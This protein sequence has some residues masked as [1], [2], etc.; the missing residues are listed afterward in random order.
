MVA[1]RGELAVRLDG[2]IG[3]SRLFSDERNAGESIMP[4]HFHA[5]V[6]QSGLWPVRQ[7]MSHRLPRRIVLK[8]CRETDE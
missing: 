3:I 2:R 1:L 6:F 8:R 4:R 5:R 7:S